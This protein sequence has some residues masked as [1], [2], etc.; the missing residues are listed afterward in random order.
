MGYKQKSGPLQRA[1][2]D[3]DATSPFQQVSKTQD[4]KWKLEALEQE[5]KGKLESD[6]TASVPKG[7]GATESSTYSV[8][9]KQM[10]DDALTRGAKRINPKLDSTSGEEMSDFKGASYLTD[11]QTRADVEFE[12]KFGSG[13]VG[14][15]K[16]PNNA[17]KE[18]VKTIQEM[19]IAATQAYK[20]GTTGIQTVS[21]DTSKKLQTFETT[22]G[23]M[24][25]GEKRIYGATKV[26]KTDT[27]YKMYKVREKPSKKKFG[28]EG[29]NYSEDKT[30]SFFTQN[31]DVLKGTNPYL[32]RK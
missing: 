13:A 3:K 22:G 2:Y 11:S 7:L 19:N 9:P 1:G 24:K 12:S 10:K 31:S 20:P 21:K 15:H 17:S 29:V 6:F 32:K 18:D 28:F 30:K 8:K 25:T 14:R 26:S 27:G 16:I 5:A 4:T 23:N